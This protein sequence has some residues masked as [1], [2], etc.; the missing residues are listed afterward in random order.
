MGSDI[1][2]LLGKVSKA[3]GVILES[4]KLRLE[5]GSSRYCP[6]KLGVV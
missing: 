4:A 5:K 1:S 2:I 6:L 3:F